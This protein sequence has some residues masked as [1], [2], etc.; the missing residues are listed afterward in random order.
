MSYPTKYTRQYDYVAYQ[1]TN[2]SRPLPATRVHADLNLLASLSDE[3]VEFLKL[4]TR[5][6]G[7]LANE[8]VGL[9]QLEAS[10]A[11]MIGDTTA[12]DDLVEASDAA[13]AAA[14][15]ADASA[16]S[17]STSASNAASS[18]GAASTSASGASTSASAAAT[19]ASNAAA[20]LASALVGVAS[21][22]DSELVLYSGTTG[23][24]SKR[25]SLTGVLKATSGV[26]S[27]AV[28]GTDFQAA[29]AQLF[30]NLPQVTVSGATYTTVATDAQKHLLH[31]TSESGARTAT[32]AA[33]ASVPYPIGTEITFVNQNGAGVLTIS[34]NSDTMRLAGAGT[35]GSRSL[36]ANG[37]A[38]ALKL[39]ATE[40]IIY[41]TG[42]T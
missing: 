2:P 15:A 39:T 35:T 36:A 4:F 14:A 11:A 41:G 7:A 22:V 16:D 12:V 10:V 30:S 26:L 31:P 5:S 1:N 3:T 40:W 21:S 33:N 20:T 18:A 24:A 42:L 29:D 13:V 37:V 9:D 27:A 28:A 8:S 19:S 38:T 34:I 23:K 25:A 17:A 32:I 6:D